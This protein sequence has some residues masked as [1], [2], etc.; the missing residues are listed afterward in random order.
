MEEMVRK[1]IRITIAITRYLRVYC[2]FAIFGIAILE[3]PNC[4]GDRWLTFLK[5]CYW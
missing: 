3:F 4:L 5:R 1:L 2:V